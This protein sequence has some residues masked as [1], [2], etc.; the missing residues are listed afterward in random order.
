MAT[1]LHKTTNTQRNTAHRRVADSAISLDRSQQLPESDDIDSILYQNKEANIQLKLTSLLQTTLK[2]EPLF[3]LFFGQL[4]HLLKVSGCNY[5]HPEKNLDINIGK[6]ATHTTDYSLQLEDIY[7]GNIVLQRKQRF[8]E[9]ELV[10]IESLLGILIYPLRNA[11]SYRD[12]IKQAL[13]DPLTG[14]GNRGALEQALDHQWQMAQRY[15]QHFCVLMLDIDHFKN[16]NDTHGHAA[17]DS[18]IKAVADSIVD[19]TRQTD[20]AYRYGGEEF[21]VILNKS[22]LAGAAIIAERIRENIAALSIPIDNEGNTLINVTVSIGGSCSA[23]SSNSGELVKQAD[24]VLYYAKNSGRNRV[25][26]SQQH[27]KNRTQRNLLVSS[28]NPL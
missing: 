7:L 12:A 19:T 17:G 16:I 23:T 21:L 27:D 15:D 25:E 9:E 3:D 4:Q 26:L 8:S 22:E 11:L 14:L 10:H 5:C 20:L 28:D 13:C 2:I 24:K 6:A 1:T 18:V